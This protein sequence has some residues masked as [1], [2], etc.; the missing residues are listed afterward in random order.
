MDKIPGLYESLSEVPF[1]PNSLFISAGIEIKNVVIIFNDFFTLISLTLLLSVLLIIC[2]NA[3]NNVSNRKYE[4]GVFKAIGMP[5]K[6]ISFIFIFQI[7]ISTLVTIL[8]FTPGV[9]IFTNITNNILFDSFMVYLK[10]PA[11]K[12]INILTFYPHIFVLDIFVLFILNAI[13][14]LIPLMKMKS[15]KPLHILR[16]GRN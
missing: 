12:M 2:F 4:I 8:L 5:N 1:V 16:R 13:T 14:T 7:I 9:F 10:N 11:L 3:L 15:L 6:N